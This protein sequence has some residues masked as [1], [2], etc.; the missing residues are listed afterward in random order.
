MKCKHTTVILYRHEFIV[1]KSHDTFIVYNTKKS[2]E[3]GHSHFHNFNAVI[4][5][6][7][8]TER[9]EIPRNKSKW[10]LNSIL[11]INKDKDYEMKIKDLMINYK[12]LMEDNPGIDDRKCL[13]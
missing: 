6:I 1:M 7:K 2:F 8:L 4:S 10:F 12:Y 13:K 5:A 9:K 11:R 3:N